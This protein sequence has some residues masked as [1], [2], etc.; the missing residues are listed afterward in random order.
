MAT[1]DELL[2]AL[3]VRYREAQRAEKGRILTEFVEVRL[4]AF[5]S[6]V[7]S[8]SVITTPAMRA[9]MRGIETRIARLRRSTGSAG[10]QG[11]EPTLDLGAGRLDR[12]DHRATARGVAFVEDLPEAG[13][14]H[15]DELGQLATAGGG[16]FQRKSFWLWHRVGYGRA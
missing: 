7:S 12:R 10:D 3:V 2:G 14:R 6:N 15:G 8:S 16:R 11:L 4:A 1:R 13:L 9:P 5:R